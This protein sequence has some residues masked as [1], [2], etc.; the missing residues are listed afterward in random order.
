MGQANAAGARLLAE[1][2]PT[3]RNRVMH[4][5]Y[6]FAGFTEHSERDGVI[7][8]AGPA[9]EAPEPPSYLRLQ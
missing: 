5:T 3:D 2:V 4:I 6:R 1:F 8:L 7:T 9:G